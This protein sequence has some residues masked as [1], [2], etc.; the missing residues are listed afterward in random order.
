MPTDNPKAL[1]TLQMR[2]GSKTTGRAPLDRVDINVDIIDGNRDRVSVLITPR[3][4]ATPGFA[5]MILYRESN[6]RG[7]F[8]A[9]SVWFDDRCFRVTLV[10]VG[11]NLAGKLIPGFYRIEVEEITAD[12]RGLV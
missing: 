8:D 11:D 6:D 7:V 1:R 10:E 9:T 5:D 12:L 2:A 4:K 3:W